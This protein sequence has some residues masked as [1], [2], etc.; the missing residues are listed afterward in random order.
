MKLD[1]CRLLR[2]RRRPFARMT[3]TCTGRRESHRS[4]AMEARSHIE[5]VPRGPGLTSLAKEML[6]AILPSL[7][8]TRAQGWNRTRGPPKTAIRRSRSKRNKRAVKPAIRTG[9]PRTTA[10]LAN[11]DPA[12]TAFQSTARP[13]AAPRIAQLAPPA[14]AKPQLRQ[15]ALIRAITRFQTAHWDCSDSWRCS[16]CA[17][18]ANAEHRTAEIRTNPAVTPS[19]P[20]RTKQPR[21]SHPTPQNS[22]N[23]PFTPNA[24]YPAVTASRANSRQLS[25]ELLRGEGIAAAGPVNEVQVIAMVRADVAGEQGLK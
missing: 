14:S 13:T 4:A 15:A 6:K 5:K 19:H 22:P 23:L 16:H 7:Y 12:Q 8:P 11:P 20:A 24:T 18:A 2:A 10:S 17:E 25:L 3:S 9:L 1:A 21:P